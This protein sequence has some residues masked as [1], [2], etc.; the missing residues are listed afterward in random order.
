MWTETASSDSADALTDLSIGG[1]PYLT[2]G[3]IFHLVSRRRRQC[4][5][6]DQ[7]SKGREAKPQDHTKNEQ[8]QDHS[9]Q[10]FGTITTTGKVLEGI[11]FSGQPQF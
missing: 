2:D 9:L 1:H 6:P 5:K 8:Y 10:T 4:I 7:I 11:D 3:F